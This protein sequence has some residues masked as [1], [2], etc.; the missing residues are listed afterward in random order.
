MIKRPF[1][2]L[3][4]HCASVHK[5]E[6]NT[7]LGAKNG[8]ICRASIHTGLNVSLKSHKIMQNKSRIKIKLHLTLYL[9]FTNRWRH[10]ARGKGAMLWN[11]GGNVCNL[12]LHVRNLTIFFCN[13]WQITARKKI[14]RLLFYVNM[15]VIIV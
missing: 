15:Q 6:G 11:V 2:G 1:V 7:S 4:A 9:Q 14:S 8:L 10:C 13:K 5:L 12:H 3:V